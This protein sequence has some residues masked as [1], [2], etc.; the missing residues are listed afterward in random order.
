[1]P[2]GMR[3]QQACDVRTGV[4]LVAAIT[5]A[6][7]NGRLVF[8]PMLIAGSHV[9][10]G[11]DA[12]HLI[13][14]VQMPLWEREGTQRKL[15]LGTAITHPGDHDGV[16]A[17]VL[18]LERN[19]PQHQGLPRGCGDGRRGD[20]RRPRCWGRF[21]SDEVQQRLGNTVMVTDVMAVPGQTFAGCPRVPQEVHGPW[22]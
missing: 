1:M 14:R 16:R 21:L 4:D 13:P 19:L 18:H 10:G 6:N 8:S 15:G 20:G 17:A 12:F 7:A 2:R 9:L 11:G 22:G 3:C 5:A